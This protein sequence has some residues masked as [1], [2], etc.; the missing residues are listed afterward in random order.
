MTDGALSATAAPPA[1]WFFSGN[2]LDPATVFGGIEAPAGYA[3][4]LCRWLSGPGPTDHHTVAHRVAGQLAAATPQPLILAGHSSGGLLALLIALQLGDRVDGLLLANTGAHARGQRNSDM[5]D[6]VRDEFGPELVAEFIDR[7]HARPLGRGVRET[8]IERALGGSPQN[9]LD[10][11]RSLRRIDLSPELARL[12]CPA[13]IIGGRLDTVRLPGHA[14]ELA[15][16]L[17]GG[18]L[19]LADSGHLSPLEDPATVQAAL[20]SLAVRISRGPQP[21]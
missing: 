20:N 5:P 15:G 17:P 8:L 19:V 7:C 12:R 2:M 14:S 11:F 1:V 3:K 4:V 6:R 13:T 9:Y 21:A 10:A 16:G 18:Q